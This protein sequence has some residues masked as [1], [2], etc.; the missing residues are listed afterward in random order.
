[1]Q[2]GR[3]HEYR[4]PLCAYYE[5]VQPF[6]SLQFLHGLS[7]AVATSLNLS[8]LVFFVSSLTWRGPTHAL[9]VHALCV[10]GTAC[11][12]LSLRQLLGRCRPESRCGWFQRSS[13]CTKHVAVMLWRGWRLG[14]TRW[15]MGCDA[16]VTHTQFCFVLFCGLW[17]SARSSL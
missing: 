6:P 12:K 7:F 13:L 8:W 5:N 17:F 14:S 4:F 1:M 10:E 2:F 9:L 11:G 15:V 16:F 3:H